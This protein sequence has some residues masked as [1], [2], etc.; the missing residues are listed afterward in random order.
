MFAVEDLAMEPRPIGVRKITASQDTYRLRVGDY[1]IIYKIFDRQLI[2]E[3]I[4]VRD[5][6]EAYK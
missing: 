1:R 4:K 3:I 6:K 5:R 2:I